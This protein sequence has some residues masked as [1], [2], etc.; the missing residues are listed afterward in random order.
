MK[1]DVAYLKPN[2]EREDDVVA[3]RQPAE[4]ALPRREKHD[5]GDV[6]DP[7]D[8]PNAAARVVV[9]MESVNR[10]VGRIHCKKDSGERSMSKGNTTKGKRRRNVT[11]PMPTMRHPTRVM[12]PTVNMNQTEMAS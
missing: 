6:D 2:G 5:C 4:N 9:L 3:Q 11:L 7:V 10:R 8:D 1:G 12:K